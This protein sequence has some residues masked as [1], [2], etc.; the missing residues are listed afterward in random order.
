M[1]DAQWAALMIPIGI[2]FLF[3]REAYGKIAALYPSPA[4]PV[5][6]LLTLEA[7]EEIA[8]GN[9]EVRSMEADVHAMKADVI[10]RIVNSVLYEKYML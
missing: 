4:G 10:D 9:P 1:T 2:A 3:R 5:E 8:R 7:W 6:S